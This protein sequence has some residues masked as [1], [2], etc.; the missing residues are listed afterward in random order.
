[1][2]FRSINRPDITADLADVVQ[3]R[4]RYAVATTPV[5]GTR[6]TASYKGTTLAGVLVEGS[7]PS[8][9]RVHAVDLAEGRFFNDLED[10]A[11]RNVVVLG[12][13]L[14]DNLF[15]NEHAIGKSIRIRGSRY[16][17]IGVLARK[18]SSSEGGGT[19]DNQVK[20][21]FNTFKK[22]FGTLHRSVSV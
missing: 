11:A 15:P 9:E 1:T 7:R 22:Q 20:I 8:F 13:T 18:G 6:A 4:S 19:F 16:E 12:S 17:V 10:R 2:L 21:P 3:E 14:A 5:L